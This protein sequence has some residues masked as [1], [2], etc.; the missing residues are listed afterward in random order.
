MT[1]KQFTEFTCDQCELKEITEGGIPKER[2]WIKVNT[3]TIS[4][5]GTQ[6][7]HQEFLFCSP[8]CY[9]KKNV[10]EIWKVKK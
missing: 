8:E 1:E 5:M 9:A 2:K 10:F 4:T 6:S 3:S 7:L